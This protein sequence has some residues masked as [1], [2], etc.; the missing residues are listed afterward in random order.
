MRISMLA[1]IIATL[2]ACGGATQTAAPGGALSPTTAAPPVVHA[3]EFAAGVSAFDQGDYASARTDFET[4]SKANAN[5]D[6]ALWRLGQTCEKLGDAPA[7][8]SAYRAE[9]AITPG[10]ELASAALANLY[11]AQGNT[12]A[13]LATATAGLANHPGSALLH[14]AMGAAL[15]TH[16]DQD[17]A[18][19]QFQQA[20]QLA[21]L[22]PKLHFAF[23]VWLNRW[24][25]R[26]AAPHLDIA[27]PLVQSD[28]PMVVSIGHEYRLAGDFDSCVHTFDGAIKT[29]DGGE[30]RTERALCKLGLKDEPGAL[31]DLKSAV[32]TE[33]SY[34]QGHFFLAGRLAGTKHFKDAATE[35]AA[36]LQLAPNGSLSEQASE[37]L[38]AAQDAAASEKPDKSIASAGRN[39]GR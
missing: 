33:P 34:P 3:P 13:A 12:D 19:Q 35:Y 26:G 23:A 17:P 27:L 18:M 25:V 20:I 8:A 32:Q 29:R 4:A 22:D 9:L 15:A 21:P 30:V 36:Y 37:R 28:Y 31:A 16:G 5:D 14:G 10:A 6:E 2:S 11:V 1:L 38:K 24:H 39:R 7:A